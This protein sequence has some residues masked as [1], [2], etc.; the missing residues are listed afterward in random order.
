VT[1]T[2]T[3]TLTYQWKKNGSA[4]SGATSSSYTT[5][6]AVASDN[7]AV[8]TVTVTG[9]SGNVTSSAATLTVTAPPSITAQPSSKSVLTGQTA[10]FS[11]AATGTATLTYQ[12]SMSG[13]AI[14]GATSA[15]Y[16]TPATTSADNGAQFTVTVTN[17]AGSVTSN[18]A[19]LTVSAATAILNASQS[20][21]SFSSVNIGSS[22][23][24]PVTFTNNGNSN[25]TISNVSLSGAGYAA[26][27]VQTGQILAPG[28]V[29]TMNVT[30]TPATAGSL[31]GSV[32]VTSN[33]SNSPATVSLS[34]TGV[35]AVTHSVTL[36][37]TAST[38]AVTGYNVYRSSTSG[39]P[40]TKMNS[41][42]IAATTY[43][44]S[45]V[46]SGQTYFYVVTAVDSSNVESANSAEVSAVVP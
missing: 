20:S 22:K 5:P 11:V 14:S 27:G 26:S 33:A 39:G 3:G 19:T 17:A 10:T 16:T 23:S 25:V 45:T 4:I 41:T 21:L 8:F 42:I 6:A 34:G 18:P 32:T 44:D 28:Q 43:V 7:G 36:S 24:L 38:S 29:G 35:Q 13:V 30:F 15:T 1:A 37:W 31:P 2:G 46:I 12:W 9:T 40:Y